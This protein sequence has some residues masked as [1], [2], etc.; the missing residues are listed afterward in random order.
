MTIGKPGLFNRS[1]LPG[2][3]GMA[4]VVLGALVVAAALAVWLLGGWQFWCGPALLVGAAL[5]ALPIQRARR[6]ALDRTIAAVLE[7]WG[8]ER[9]LIFQPTTHNSRTTPTLDRGGQLSA[10]LVGAIGG[11]LHGFLAHYTYTVQ[12]GKNSYTI[13]MS[14]AVARF[15]GREGLRLRIGAKHPLGGDSFG[16]FDQWHGFETG[17]AEVDDRYIVEAGDGHDPLQLR[18]LLD[19]TVLVGLID[20]ETPMLVE[21]DHGTLLVAVG[22][23]IGIDDGVEDL[24]WFDRLREEADRWGARIGG[25]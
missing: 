23:R 22:G 8:Q 18:E 10:V 6:H 16:V 2:A 5:I 17:S 3:R 19:P 21:I 20:D 14:V 9:G 7:P 13:R 24:A 25:I 1:A 4:L 15:A 11:D 12:S